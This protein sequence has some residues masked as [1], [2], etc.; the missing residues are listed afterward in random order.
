MP[1]LN[2]Y[3]PIALLLSYVF[4]VETLR[5][6]YT[7]TT[8]VFSHPSKK[9]TTSMYHSFITQRGQQRHPHR[10]GHQALRVRRLRGFLVELRGRRW[11][12]GADLRGPGGTRRQAER[13]AHH[14][15]RPLS[16]HRPHCHQHKRRL[17]PV[18]RHLRGA[19]VRG[20]ELLRSCGE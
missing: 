16:R 3:T 15:R 11:R 7:C 1:P 10:A 2:E 13:A 20:A 14:L 19:G 8:A 18:Q 6:A 4:F 9:N 5:L 12:G 17:L